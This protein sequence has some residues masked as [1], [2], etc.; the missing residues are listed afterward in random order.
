MANSDSRLLRSRSPTNDSRAVISEKLAGTKPTSSAAKGSSRVARSLLSTAT[1]IT[2]RAATTS[3]C[4]SRKVSSAI[5]STIR[6]SLS[7][8]RTSR[9]VIVEIVCVFIGVLVVKWW[10]WNMLVGAKHSHGIIPSIR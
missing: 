9:R 1:L 3:S 10:L 6:Q 2:W 8:S 7:V 5:G 4:G